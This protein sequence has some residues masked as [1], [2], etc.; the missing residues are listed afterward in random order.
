[1][2]IATAKGDSDLRFWAAVSVVRLTDGAIA[3]EAIVAPISE[4]WRSFD[5]VE[6][7]L[8][9]RR[10]ALETLAR[11]ARLARPRRSPKRYSV[12]MGRSRC[13]LF[14]RDYRGRVLLD[15]YRLLGVLEPAVFEEAAVHTRFII[16][17]DNTHRAR[18][19]PA[20]AGPRFVVLPPVTTHNTIE[21]R[22]M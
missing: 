19:S 5:G 2:Q 14:A 3:D 9:D 22:A 6:F 20:C 7:H 1:M 13:R 17:S 15:C 21:P 16:R 10:R 11:A 4:Y 8:F 12:P 18:P